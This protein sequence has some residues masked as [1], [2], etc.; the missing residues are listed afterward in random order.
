[1]PKIFQVDAFTKEKFKGN[2]AAVCLLEKPADE[3]WMQSVAAEMNLSETAFLSPRDNGYDLQWFTPTV[4]VD[5]CGHATLA[6]ACV[7]YENEIVPANE[8]IH[9]FTKSGVLKARR[10]GDVLELDFPA[11]P[12]TEI[13]PP[14]V[15]LRALG[16]APLYV[17]QN[18]LDV[19]VQVSEDTMVKE[20]NPDFQAL[21]QIPARGIIL[22][23]R[24]SNSDFD[25]V[26]RYFAPREGINEDPVTGSAHC[27]L[28]PFWA[29]RLGKKEFT[30]FQA[31]KRSGIVNLRLR[32]DRVILAGHAIILLR[33]DF[34]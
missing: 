2:P 11:E 20:F 15:L 30:A 4:Q 25:F 14:P 9:F 26:S 7:L 6:A 28:G 16:L 31:S 10:R 21:A 19:L 12:A 18:R 33:G 3:T 13:V 32:G 24:S 17:G 27:C 23:S 8:E 34:L 29:Q 22:T 5:L 1:M